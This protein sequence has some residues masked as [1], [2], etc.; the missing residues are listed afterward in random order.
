M[1]TTLT[2]FGFLG[3]ALI[4]LA[5]FMMNAGK[6]R[7]DSVIFHSC[8]LLGALCVMLSLIAG[9][10]LSIFLLECAWASIA[11]FGLWR[12]KR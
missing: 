10:N 9:W 11:C 12:C 8:N 3:S 1:D 6:W 5:Y 4:L 7:D 2:A